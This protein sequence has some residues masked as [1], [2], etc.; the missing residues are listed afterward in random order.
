[1][2][3]TLKVLKAGN[4]DCFLIRFFGDDNK[5]K[6][7]LIDGGNKKSEYNKHLKAELLA[8]QNR[9]EKIDLLVITHTDQDHI[10]G[11]YYL[12]S[13]NKIDKSIIQEI[14][15]NSFYPDKDIISSENNDIS[16]LE[17][18]KVQTLVNESKIVR[19]SNIYLPIFNFHNFYGLELTLLSPYKE[20]VEKLQIEN[21]KNYPSDISS[22]SKDY[23]FSIQEL[24]EKNSKI[25]ISKDEDSDCKIENRVSIAFLIELEKKSILF[26]GDAN[27]DILV[28]SITKLLKEKN[29]DKLKV[30]YV[31][32]SHHGSHRSLSFDLLDLLDCNKFIISTNGGKSNLPN[33]L[34]LAKILSRKRDSSVI[35][36]FIFN[37][38]EVVDNMNFFSQ[39]FID[40][41]F[42]C[43]KPNDE[44]GYTI[45]L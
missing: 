21:S 34:T 36:S 42:E 37:Y 11:I 16:F 38:K 45:N 5:F 35:N 29:L 2:S 19:K 25:F 33:K 24:I 4:G 18:C 27:P 40:Y 9:R 30:D 15:F 43:L 17:S 12:L 22:D 14:W 7:I 28:N 31:K 1:M 10:K 8:I 32:L 39:D 6:N 13:D 26:L 20:D 23:N 41:N 3:F 44:R